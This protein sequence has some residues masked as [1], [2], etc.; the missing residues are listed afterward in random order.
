MPF[1]EH[2][3]GDGLLVLQQSQLYCHNGP[4]KSRYFVD[5]PL[6]FINGKEVSTIWCSPWEADLTPYVQEGDNAL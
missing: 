1:H 4:G 2:R 3:S 5:T 6:V